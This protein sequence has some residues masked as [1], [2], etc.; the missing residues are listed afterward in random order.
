[1]EKLPIEHM[2]SEEIISLSLPNL[3]KAIALA[4]DELA[5][6]V[7]HMLKISDKLKLLEARKRE[8]LDRGAASVTPA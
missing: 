6:R 5:V 8:L 7:K 4:E 2:C 1:M 3:E